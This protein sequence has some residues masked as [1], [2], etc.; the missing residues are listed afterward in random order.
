MSSS[1][2]T[3]KLY[4]FLGIQM[5]LSF[6]FMFYHILSCLI[7]FPHIFVWSSNFLFDIRRPVSAS[8]RRLR[9]AVNLSLLSCLYQFVL[10]TCLYQLVSI[11]SLWI[12]WTPYRRRGFF[13]WQARHLVTLRSLWSFWMPL[14]PRLLCV[15]GAALGDS[16]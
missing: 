13:A 5:I 9:P 1:L 14:T 4:T 2:Q 12:P 15:A 11:S 6:F 10:S 7:V 8:R 16:L 3:L